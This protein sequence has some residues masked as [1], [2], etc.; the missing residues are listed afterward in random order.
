[1]PYEGA[2]LWDVDGTLLTTAKAGRLALRDA[3]LDLCGVELDYG[4]LATSGLTDSAVHA[5]ALRSAGIEPK[6]ELVS[7]ISAEYVRR[8]PDALPLREG[9]V[10]PGILEALE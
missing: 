6:P 1:M 9:G 8:L 5:T 2:I 3:V 7:R 4:D 10:L